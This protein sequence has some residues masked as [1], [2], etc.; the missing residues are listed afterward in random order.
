MANGF[1]KKLG[2]GRWRV[3]W[4]DPDGANRSRTFDKKAEAD[5]WLAQVRRDT[6]L[7]SLPLPRATR[8]ITLGEFAG[9]WWERKRPTLRTK[10]AVVYDTALRLHL[11]TNLLSTELGR[12]KPR[13]LEQA[14]AGLSKPTAQKVRQVLSQVFAE[15]VRYELCD[16]NPA[17]LVRV[18]SNH[19]SET[20]LRPETLPSVAE[21]EKLALLVPERHK[22]LVLVAAFAGLRLGEACGLHPSNI[23]LEGRTIRVAQQWSFVDKGFTAP[24]TRAGNRTTIFAERIADDLSY[25][26]ARYSTEGL[27]FPNMQGRPI[28][29]SNFRLRAWRPAVE[30]L[31]RPDLHYHDLRHIF[32]STLIAGGVNVALV[33]RLMGHSTPQV[34][35]TVY[36]HFFESDYETARAAL[37]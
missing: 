23:D 34:T 26:L 32:A 12:V 10:T 13:D 1:T 4:R 22:A 16:R 18:A 21:V 11:P 6:A 33:A 25:H 24:K 17:A 3:R 14:L 31:G 36:S 19:E 35:M 9:Q 29:P 7:G 28:N 20:D 27:A 8:T 15:A 2:N 30:Q 37:T 5:Q